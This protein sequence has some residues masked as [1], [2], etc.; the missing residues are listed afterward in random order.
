M[1]TT[2]INTRE[3]HQPWC[4]AVETGSGT[5]LYLYDTRREAVA[6]IDDHDENYN[7]EV[8]RTAKALA[9]Y[10]DAIM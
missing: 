6:A 7:R 9:Q 10:P 8:M 1:T 4:M 3:N 5:H 2:T